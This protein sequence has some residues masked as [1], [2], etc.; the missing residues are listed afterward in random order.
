MAAGTVDFPHVVRPNV[1]A[2]IDRILSLTPK[3]AVR[4]H[5]LLE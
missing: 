3:L 5:T 2:T 4:L 1:R